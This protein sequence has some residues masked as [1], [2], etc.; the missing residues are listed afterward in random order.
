MTSFN[1]VLITTSGIGSRLG[2]LTKFTNKC[3]VR[4]GDIPT[5]SHIIKSYP[6]TTN[7]VITLGYF[8]DQVKDYIELV[9]PNLSFKFVKVDNFDGPGS[10]LLYSILKAKEFLQE[11]FIYHASDTIIGE[12]INLNPEA[13]F[14]S[15]VIGRGSSVYA[16]FSTQGKR[17]SEMYPKGYD[18]SDYLHIGQIGIYNFEFFW[19]L[20]NNIYSNDPNN[21]N[22]GDV[23]VL[24]QMVK[25]FNFDV[26][27]VSSWYDI[28]N[29]E[30]L[31]STRKKIGNASF[32]VL[33]KLAESIYKV[34]NSVVKFFHDKDVLQK[35]VE[36][37]VFLN[38]LV[39]NITGVKANFYKYD[40]VK[41][42]LFANVANRNN[43]L[44][45]INWAEENLWVASQDFDQA[46]FNQ[47]CSDF[48]FQKTYQRINDFFVKKGLVDE[49]S[50]INGEVIPPIYQLLSQIEPDWLLNTNPTGFHGDFILDNILMLPNGDFKLIDWRQ[51]F[52]GNL[53]Y[54]DQ[55]YDLAKMAHNLVVNHDLI[56]KDL[57]K[58]EFSSNGHI[59]LNIHR[60][61]TLVECEFILF[62]YLKTKKY[63]VR[64]VEILRAIIWL[65]MSPLHHHPFD[66]FLFYFGKYNLFNVLKKYGKI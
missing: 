57:F 1:S 56:D 20:A 38:G 9:H 39:P 11:P 40:F 64:K 12:P 33:E 48:Y 32:H 54:G 63:D 31:E 16:S 36:R 7:F 24:H 3:L 51:D 22:L 55:Y 26:N 65:N 10:S 8:G 52:S 59:S 44:K 27:V 4:I 35:R 66:T 60:L 53:A 29:L 17:V 41:G 34:D 14:I 58:I 21:S 62:E 2:D 49:E 18:S 5:I 19:E 43:F 28:G 47:R 13:N 30:A 37:T 42:D 50:V 15:G 25:L 6:S 45:L 23:D 61:Q 46:D